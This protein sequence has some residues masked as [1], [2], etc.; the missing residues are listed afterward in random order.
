MTSQ[1]KEPD[2]LKEAPITLRNRKLSKGELLEKYAGKE[3]NEFWQW[4]GFAEYGPGDYFMVPDDQGDVIMVTSTTELMTTKPEVR[5]LIPIGT[6]R[7]A[8]SRLLKK[9]AKEIRTDGV[10]MEER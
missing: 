5:V 4:D 1:V 9:I 6:T 2:W 7:Y 8:A 10:G 3:A